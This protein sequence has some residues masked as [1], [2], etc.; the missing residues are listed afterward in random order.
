MSGVVPPEELPYEESFLRGVP[1]RYLRL[2]ELAGGFMENR[3]L[4]RDG[5]W[6]VSAGGQTRAYLLLRKG[7]PFRIVGRP[8]TSFDDFMKWLAA[9]DGE[10]LLT[11]NF[12]HEGALPHV[13]R[14]LEENPVLRGLEGDGGEISGLYS[15][16]NDS[17][18]SG[19]FRLY[20]GG[21]AVL[22]PVGDGRAEAAFLTG[23]MLGPDEADGLLDADGGSGTTASFH[24]G[25]SRKVTAVGLAET[26]M[27]LEAFNV[28]YRKLSEDWQECFVVA[29]KAFAELKEKRSYLQDL[30]LHPDEGFRTRGVLRK[31]EKLPALVAAMV[32]RVAGAHSDPAGAVKLF[33]LVNASRRHALASV[34][35]GKLVGRPAGGG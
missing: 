34:G 21:G 20:T 15:S 6:R 22:V 12:L 23:D 30:M 5:Y 17:G 19:L 18:E 31:P 29:V 1:M 26:R 16:M 32:K 3:A 4:R 33:R 35:L 9:D 25:A 24:P 7:E 11:C 14:C 2:K 28:W 13:L 8:T 27:L 10:L